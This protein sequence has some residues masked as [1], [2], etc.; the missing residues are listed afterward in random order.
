VFDTDSSADYPLIVP[1]QKDLDMDSKERKERCRAM[2]AA[3]EADIAWLE[4]QSQKG[5]TDQAPAAEGE[6][7]TKLSYPW[8]IQTLRR[9]IK[10]YKWIARQLV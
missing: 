7:P 4:E 1:P 9:N 8:A 10:A 3:L 2:I 6:K 5:Q